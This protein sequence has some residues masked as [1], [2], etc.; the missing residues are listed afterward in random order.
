M[1]FGG[2]FS[3]LLEIKCVKFY[4][5]SFRFDISNVQHLGVFFFPD[6]VYRIYGTEWLILC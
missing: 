5:D 2:R 3:N 4:S 6:T 1:K